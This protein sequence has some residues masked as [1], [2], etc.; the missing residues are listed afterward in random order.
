MDIEELN[1]QSWYLAQYITGGKNR[2]R[3]FDWL[4]DQSVMPWTPL[5]IR[6]IRR[7]D[8]VNCSRRYITPLF[9]G[10]FFLKANLDTQPVDRFRRHSAFRRFVMN[11][12]Q[13]A[14]LRSAVIEDLMKLYPE[15]SLAPGAQEK[16]R[17]SSDTWLSDEQYRFLIRMEQ[18]PLPTSRVALLMQLVFEPGLL[19]F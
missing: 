16:L 11:G 13:I 10:Y 19:G 8:K 1:G 3:L 9:P 7:T 2:E 17:K 5:T 12:A 14:P 6:T 4:S 15:P 18:E